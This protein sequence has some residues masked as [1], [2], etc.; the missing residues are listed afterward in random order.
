MLARQE[1]LQ[2]AV[3]GNRTVPDWVAMQTLRLYREQIAAGLPHQEAV[4]VAQQQMIDIL[5]DA[6]QI[7]RRQ[8]LERLWRDQIAPWG[9]IV[10][11]VAACVGWYFLWE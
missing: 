2:E 3:E 4:A 9:V 5:N 7:R 8:R 10:L 6:D 11:G 1:I